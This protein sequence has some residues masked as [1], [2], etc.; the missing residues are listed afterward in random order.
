VVKPDSTVQKRLVVAGL[1]HKGMTVI[2]KGLQPG[3][4]VV[5][6]GQLRLRDGS[7]V[8]AQAAMGTAAQLNNGRTP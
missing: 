4:T 2:E 6:V 5:T 1:S 7:P 3:E 8:K